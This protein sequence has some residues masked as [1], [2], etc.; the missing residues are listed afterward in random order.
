MDPGERAAVVVEAFQGQLDFYASLAL[1]LL[2]ATSGVVVLLLTGR[3]RTCNPIAYWAGH[4]VATAP[5]VILLLLGAGAKEQLIT[6]LAIAYKTN[7]DDTMSFLIEKA[8]G[9]FTCQLVLLIS[10]IA[11]ELA[12]AI[13]SIRWSTTDA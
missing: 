7:F 6:R 13:V 12:A 8:E 5:P 3:R 10:G 11:I 9:I 1:L 4:A 2:T